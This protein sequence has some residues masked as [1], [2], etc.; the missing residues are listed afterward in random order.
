[1]HDKVFGE[2][3]YEYGWF[4]NYTYKIFDT[5]AKI[6]LVIPCDE[7]QEIEPAQ[8]D[9]FIRFDSNKNDMAA[10]AE[11]AIFSYYLGIVDEYREKLGVE[12]ADELAP[13]IDKPDHLA[14][15]VKPTEIIFQQSFSSQD[16]IVGL[17][18]TCAWEPELGLAVKF[19]NEL[20]ED[21]G[22]QDIVL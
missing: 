9:A 7:G 6:K 20:I 11:K 21:V 17:L 22:T 15:L 13:K 16:R 14:L 3:D 8:K 5:E 10:S 4:R 18:F 1:M 2:I 19:V 12:F